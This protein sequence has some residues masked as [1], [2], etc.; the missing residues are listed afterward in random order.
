[1]TFH[2]FFDFFFVCGLIFKLIIIDIFVKLNSKFQPYLKFRKRLK[3]IKNELRAPIPI[4]LRLY[5]SYERIIGRSIL[6]LKLQ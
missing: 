5:G 4:K 3:M 6:F 2:E 1:M